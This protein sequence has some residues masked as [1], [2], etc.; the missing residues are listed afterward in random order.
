MTILHGYAQ[1]RPDHLTEALAAC[2]SVRSASVLE[3]GCERYD[4]FQSP[5]IPGLVVFVEEWTSREHL[6]TH[7]QQDA[8]KAFFAA[9]S[10]FL[11]REPEIRI[12]E[13]SLS[14]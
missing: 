3:P 11:E 13:A 6:E 12:F 9:I 4:F 14:A 10:P 8:F 1:F 5:R 2:E 7:F